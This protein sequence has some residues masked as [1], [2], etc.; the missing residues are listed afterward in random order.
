MSSALAGGLGPGVNAN[1]S[2]NPSPQVHGGGTLD[3]KGLKPLPPTWPMAESEDDRKS[4]AIH[5]ELL[6]A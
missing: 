3:G 6:K 5:I 1:A 4:W 2:D